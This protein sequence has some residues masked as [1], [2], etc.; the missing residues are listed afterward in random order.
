[1]RAKLHA[2]YEQVDAKFLRPKP[3]GPKPWRP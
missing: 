3:G 2:W 1:M